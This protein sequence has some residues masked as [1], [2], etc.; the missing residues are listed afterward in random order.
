MRDNF[1]AEVTTLAGSDPRIV[2]LMADIGNHMFDEFKEQYP[3]RFFNCGIAESNMISVAA[4]LAMS[5]LRPFVYTFSA[6]DIGRPFEQIRVDLAFQNLPVV[7]IGLGGGLTYSPLGPTHY[8]CEDLA[9]IRSLPNMTVICPADAIETRAAIRASL[10]QNGPAYI[11]IGK[12]NEPVIHEKP[13]DFIIGKG[14]TLTEGSDICILGAGTIMPEVLAAAQKIRESGLEPRVISF[15]T[16]KPLDTDLLK[17]VF[18]EYPLIVT[19]EEHSLIGGL[20]SAVAEWICDQGTMRKGQLL[21]IGI[22]DEFLHY[23][24][25]Q[26]TAREAYGL[27]PHKLAETILEHYKKI[28]RSMS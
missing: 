12:K 7:I 3:A 24:I 27:S 8:I 15:H 18:S 11:R 6:F 4:G 20:G 26:K 13:P 1:S 23:A 2:L 19:V 10:L 16:I 22:P 25:H 5:G 14:I 21:R 28:P 17:E 9:I